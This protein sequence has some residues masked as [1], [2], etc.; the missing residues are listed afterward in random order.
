[1]TGFGAGEARL[2]LEA[3]ALP[4]LRVEHDLTVA[5]IAA[6]PDGMTEFRPSPGARTA[7]ELARHIVTTELRFLTGA[8]RGAF[9]LDGPALSAAEVPGAL[10][11]AYR[12]GFASA[13]AA[14]ARTAGEALLAPLDYKGVVRMPALG[15]VQFAV[16]HTIHHRGQLSVYFRAA[17]LPVPRIY[18]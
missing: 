8:A 13:I 9:D 6:I 10:V 16:N 2:V 12:E 7:G 17:G 3:V 5:V 15:F 1:M 14:L 4:T 11:Q 18:G